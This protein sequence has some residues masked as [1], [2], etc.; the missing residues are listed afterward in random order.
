MENVRDKLLEE[1]SAQEKLVKDKETKLA[2]LQAEIN[3]MQDA[4]T[5]HRR[6]L[7]QKLDVNKKELE[8]ALELK[9]EL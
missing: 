1:K 8:A 7:L 9:N 3:R 4:F 2:T 6:E 5:Q